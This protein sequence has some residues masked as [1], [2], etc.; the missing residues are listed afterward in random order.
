MKGMIKQNVSKK[1]KPFWQ[2]II[3]AFLYVVV[4]NYL[5]TLCNTLGRKY[6]NFASLAILFLS[7]L[8]VVI[9]I[10]RFLTG[11]EYLLIDNKLIFKKHARNRDKKL[12]EIEVNEIQFLKPYKE[13]KSKK[14]ISYTY[15]F[16][17]DREYDKFYVGEFTREGKRYRFVFKPSERM[18]NILY[19]NIEESVM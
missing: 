11:Y 2:I 5:I 16:V 13:I 17:C 18:I 19:K 10:Y 9:F 14:D 6:V 1:A 8:V 12:L 7:L 3:G 15:R 4:V